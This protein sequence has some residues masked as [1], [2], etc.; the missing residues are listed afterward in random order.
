MAK[1]ED[2]AA[3][4]GAIPDSQSFGMTL[5]NRAHSFWGLLHEGE[6]HLCP[7]GHC[8]K[9]T[10]I[11]MILAFYFFGCMHVGSLFPDQGC[12]LRPL[13]WKLEFLTSW[14]TRNALSYCVFNSFVYNNCIVFITQINIEDISGRPHKK[15]A[16][17]SESYW[18]QNRGG[19]GI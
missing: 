14:T 19:K 11:M 15:P 17:T 4:F 13:H 3:S 18:R 6:K 10:F 1:K 5:W 9:K 12:N 2:K 16:L 8:I 7:L